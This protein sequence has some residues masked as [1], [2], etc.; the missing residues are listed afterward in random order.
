M[1]Q[2]R[3]LWV[4]YGQ[5]GGRAELQLS[6]STDGLLLLGGRANE[7]AALVSLSAQ[8]AGLET[9]VLDLDCSFPRSASGYFERVDF[10]SL[11]Y[12]AFRIDEEA[13]PLHAQ[14][15]A[16]AYTVALD[17]SS[18]EESIVVSALQKL[19]AQ[20]NMA[21][22][23]VLFDALGSVEGFRGFYV[24]K[25]KGR[26]G[27][28]KLLEAVD[29]ESLSRA[30][31]ADTLVS[32]EGAPYPL[33]AELAASLFLAKVLATRGHSAATGAVFLTGAHR[34]F[35]AGTRVS[36]GNRL[37]LHLLE[38]PFP[39]VFATGLEPALSP[40]LSKS[41]Q[42]RV[43]CSD[44]WHQGGGERPRI[45]QS[46]LLAEVARSG[47]RTVFV[48]R[49]FPSREREVKPAS[50]GGEPNRDLTMELLEEVERFPLATRESI[51]NYFS[52]EHLPADINDE[53]DR[54]YS[55]N[56]LILEAKETG[57]GPDVFAYTLTESGRR[58]LKELRG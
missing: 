36:H 41:C 52:A 8:E 35:R 51:V 26:V 30:A 12:D 16:A 53:L 32:F 21:S 22:P 3:K 9:L 42:T 39:V 19:A 54:L 4:G 13:G 25:L 2:A 40:L 20:D 46:F 1:S 15:I 31:S 27:A 10:R 47:E 57:S 17:L 33:A 18:E 48:P 24:D 56:S 45:L 23:P 14:L 43:Y 5:T 6:G 28:L 11:L 55:A 58:L 34:I 29:D 50:L 7:T 44:A 38:A 37:L 49:L